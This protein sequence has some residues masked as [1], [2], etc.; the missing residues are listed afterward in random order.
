MEIFEDFSVGE[1]FCGCVKMESS[2]GVNAIGS[3]LPEYILME[4]DDAGL[5]ACRENGDWETVCRWSDQH[6]DGTVSGRLV[7]D[8]HGYGVVLYEKNG[9]IYTL[10]LSSVKK[11]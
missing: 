2:N 8:V 9:S 4:Y 6:L 3:F 10:T 1:R 7:C 5:Y 11:S